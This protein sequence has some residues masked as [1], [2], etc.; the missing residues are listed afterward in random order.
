MVNWISVDT[1][2]LV[3]GI[4]YWYYAAVIGFWMQGVV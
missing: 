3:L 4:R 1:G 2:H